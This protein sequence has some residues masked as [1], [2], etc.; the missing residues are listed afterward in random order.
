MM[1]RKTNKSKQIEDSIIAL[2]KLFESAIAD[3]KRFFDNAVICNALKSQGG[4]ASLNHTFEDDNITYCI[5]PLSITT[6]KAKMSTLSDGFTWET[7]D[8]LRIQAHDAIEHAHVQKAQDQKTTKIGLKESLSIAE[9]HL[10]RQRE[11]N[12]R[13]LQAVGQA[14]TILDGV[15]SIADEEL[16]AKR[17]R[18][19]KEIIYKCLSLNEFPFNKIDRTATIV[20]LHPDKKP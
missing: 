4:V 5:K 11:M 12:F 13:I 16:R 10:E 7:F 6:L 15:V 20:T 3:P 18:D 17:T 1:R 2:I 19:A 14:L 9:L 8:K